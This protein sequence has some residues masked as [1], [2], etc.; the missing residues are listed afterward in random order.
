MNI[1][2]PRREPPL[3][4]WATLAAVCFTGFV[5]AAIL[6]VQPLMV[7]ALIDG[8]RLSAAQAGLVAGAEMA[9]LAVAGLLIGTVGSS[10]NRRK[11]IAAGA[12]LGVLGSL[13]PAIAHGYGVILTLRFVAGIGAGLIASSVLAMLGATRDPDRI[14]GIYFVALYAAASAFF[15]LASFVVAHYG[16]AGGYAL[17]TAALATAWITG[18]LVPDS[19]SKARGAGSAPKAPFPLFAAAIS[20]GLSTAFWVGDGAVWAFIQRL[21]LSSGASTSEIT[22]VL[23]VSQL[24]FIGGAAVASALHTRFGRAAPTL[25]AIVLTAASAAMVG[26]THGLVIYGLG[27]FSFCF[28]WVL[29]LTYLNGTMAAQ[30]PAGRIV[31][32]GV[33]SQTV[34]MAIGPAVAGSVVNGFGYAAV[35]PTA[36]VCYAVAIVLLLVLATRR[37]A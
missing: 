36:L 18:R 19:E 9:G 28:A 23:T 32:L 5:S 4:S 25:A 16:A 11:A 15:P 1:E 27:V 34:G 21:G 13:V 33:T 17:L 20:L 14:F 22:A 24:A 35:M 8:F 7:G 30:D 12:T 6:I 37:K 10:W 31:A 26:G 2:T 29:F 3:G